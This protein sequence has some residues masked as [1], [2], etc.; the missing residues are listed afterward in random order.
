MTTGVFGV[1]LHKSNYVSSSCPHIGEKNM[2]SQ[3]CW[4]DHYDR[5]PSENQC[6]GDHTSVTFCCN[7]SG[8]CGMPVGCQVPGGPTIP[9]KEVWCGAWE[10]AFLTSTGALD[11]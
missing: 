3:K 4:V 10:S 8:F 5:S 11:A 1:P 6:D 2:L 7:A 9:G